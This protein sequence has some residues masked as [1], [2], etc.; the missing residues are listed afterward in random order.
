MSATTTTANEFRGEVGV[1]I[2]DRDVVFC[3]TLGA[4]ADLAAAFGTRN[5]FQLFAR[6]QGE[7]VETPAT[8]PETGEVKMVATASGPSMSDLPAIIC[9]MSNGAVS[10][11][12]ARRV[13]VGQ[14]QPIMTAIGSAIARAFPA[15]SEKKSDADETPTPTQTPTSPSTDISDSPSPT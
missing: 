13:E 7:I 12:E 3:L 2:G 6:L 1:R 5:N 14:F 4:L 9:A 11:D 15:P 8:D 10:A